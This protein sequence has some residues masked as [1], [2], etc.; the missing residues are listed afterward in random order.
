[1]ES[2]LPNEVSSMYETFMSSS[3][4]KFGIVD[5]EHW[6]VVCSAAKAVSLVSLFTVRFQTYERKREIEILRTCSMGSDLQEVDKTLKQIDASLENW[7]LE[8]KWFQP[9]DDDEL[10]EFRLSDK[11]TVS[12]QLADAFKLKADKDM[13]ELQGKV[14][15]QKLSWD[16]ITQMSNDD[17][18]SSSSN[19]NIVH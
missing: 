11:F 8:I 17:V 14:A 18:N 5:H 13:K 2:W 3:Y 1:M 19:V 7:Q 15:E 16:M 6:R 10:H 12:C 4:R 9:L